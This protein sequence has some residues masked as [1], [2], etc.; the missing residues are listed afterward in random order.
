MNAEAEVLKLKGPNPHE[1]EKKKIDK[2]IR[3]AV[4]EFLKQTK[5]SLSVVVPG[6]VGNGGSVDVNELISKISGLV[7]KH[8]EV[9]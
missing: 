8:D 6:G 1:V 3:Q 7:M 9:D 4:A 5:E 2:A